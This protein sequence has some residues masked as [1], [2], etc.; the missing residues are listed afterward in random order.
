[1]KVILAVAVL[2][3]APIAYA[4]PA[5][6]RDVQVSSAGLDLHDPEDA[7]VMIHRIEAVV[8]PMC[9]AP[10]YAIRKTVAACIRDVMRKTVNLTNIPALALALES[11]AAAPAI[12]LAQ[13]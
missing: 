5:K 11:R 8:R 13:R 10:G 7:A 6:L 12:V 1:M 3:A 4:E 9:V 2:V